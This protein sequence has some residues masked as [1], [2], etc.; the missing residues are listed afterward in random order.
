MNISDKSHHSDDKIEMSVLDGL[1]GMTLGKG[2]RISQEKGPVNILFK[3]ENK[4]EN[5]TYMQLDGE[6]Y[7]VVNPKCMEVKLHERM[8][9]LRILRKKE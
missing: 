5:V 9:R 1:M 6:Y 8:G 7:K 4:K 3:E 2:S